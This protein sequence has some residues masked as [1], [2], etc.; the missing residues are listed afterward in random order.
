MN[1]FRGLV[2]LSGARSGMVIRALRM[3]ITTKQ[4]SQANSG[5]LSW[6][7]RYLGCKAVK[8]NSI[9]TAK[10]PISGFA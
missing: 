2:S 6:R 1:P 8:S 7:I 4:P 9:I 3:T 5:C 10:T